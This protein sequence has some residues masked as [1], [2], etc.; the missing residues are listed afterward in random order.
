MKIPKQEKIVR[1]FIFD[2]IK[3][4]I[5]TQHET[6]RKF[7]LYKIIDNDY[8]K[9]KT[10]ESPIKFEEVIEKDRGE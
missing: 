1:S 9:L 4:Y 3:S 2:G 6:T 7:T 8:K 5:V 10:A